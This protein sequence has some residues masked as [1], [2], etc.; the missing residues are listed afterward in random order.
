M[1]W[2]V[3]MFVETFAITHGRTHVWREGLSSSIMVMDVY[4]GGPRICPTPRDVVLQDW[5]PRVVGL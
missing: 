5:G 1:S 3:N 2:E 4:P